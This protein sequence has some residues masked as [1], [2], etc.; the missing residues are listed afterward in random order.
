[1]VLCAVKIDIILFIMDV[2]L[3]NIVDIYLLQ[4]LR[5]TKGML[6]K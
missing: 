5:I 6:T 3:S 2:V 1:M 4:H